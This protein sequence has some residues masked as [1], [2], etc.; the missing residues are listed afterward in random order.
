[1]AEDEAIELALTLMP[2]YETTVLLAENDSSISE[3]DNSE[4]C[5]SQIESLPMTAFFAMA[6]EVLPPS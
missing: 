6:Q 3:D 4:S 1:M 2:E 5:L